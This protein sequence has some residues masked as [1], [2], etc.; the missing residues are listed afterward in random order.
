MQNSQLERWLIMLFLL[1]LFLVSVSACNTNGPIVTLPA[2]ETP[3]LETIYD[4]DNNLIAPFN[5]AGSFEMLPGRRFELRLRAIWPSNIQIK[6][7]NQALPEVK[8][9]ASHPE[10]DNSGYYRLFDP[11]PVATSDPR[12]F[13]RVLVVLPDDKRGSVDYTMTVHDISQN[14]NLTGSQKEA[15]PLEIKVNRTGISSPKPS[16]ILWAPDPDGKHRKTDDRYSTDGAWIMDSITLAGWLISPIDQFCCDANIEDVHYS[17]W[18]D[19]D[20]IERNYRA[21]TNSLDTAIMPGRWYT[22]LDNDFHPKVRI[23]LTSGRQ[24]DASTFLMPGSD[25]FT[26]E[27]NAWHKSRHNDLIP[28]G[29]VVQPDA[30]P[31]NAR[32]NGEVYWPFPITRPFGIAPDEPEL[33]KGDYVIITGAL[34]QDVAHLLHADPYSLS[35]D[36]QARYWRAKCWEDHYKGQGGWLEIH[37]LDSIR[38]VKAPLVRK[39]AQLIQVCDDGTYHTSPGFDGFLSAE[40]PNPPTDYSVLKFREIIDERFTDMSTVEKHIVEIAPYGPERLHVNVTTKPGANGHFMAVYL[41][42][43]E[44]GTELRPTAAPFPTGQ[45]IPEHLPACATNPYGP[46]CYRP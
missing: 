14:E 15:P 22:A 2:A 39:H 20:F 18:L 36:E 41:L 7:E 19:N 30:D 43:W 5:A 45:P 11:V 12:F 33:Q 23:P 35:F 44:E 34:V 6:I 29:W 16:E 17:I 26:V 31:Q 37:P 32:Y 9:T 3:I 1:T 8:D 46:K 38:R 10:L 25:V 42:W 21:T 13:W 28:P 4:I 40:P 24:P 27:L